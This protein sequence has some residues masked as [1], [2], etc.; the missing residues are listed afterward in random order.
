MKNI[1]RRRN[2]SKTKDIKLKKG[3]TLIELVV[4]I[5]SG[6]IITV[7]L[8]AM[9]IFISLSYNNITS[10]NNS[11][12]DSEELKLVIKDELDSYT[13]AELNNINN[14]KLIDENDNYVNDKYQYFNLSINKNEY[15]LFYIITT[16]SSNISNDI[17]EDID[18]TV[19]SINIY[20]YSLNSPLHPLHNFEFNKRT[21]LLEEDPENITNLNDYDYK[22]E[23][24]FFSDN[25]ISIVKDFDRKEYKYNPSL[26]IKNDIFNLSLYF[27]YNNEENNDNNSLFHFSYLRKE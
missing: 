18:T 10:L 8:V 5:A 4:S 25:N 11:L 15:A 26:S 2:K 17:E 12:R 22:D 14:V 6:S 23:T 21:Y 3:F 13:F 27:N 9:I 16:N 19:S 20:Y 7:G 24:L 1:I